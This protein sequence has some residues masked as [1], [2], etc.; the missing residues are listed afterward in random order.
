VFQSAEPR[1]AETIFL[2]HLVDTKWI[3][4]IFAGT[5]IAAK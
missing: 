1:R 3:K 2:F 5:R 4:R